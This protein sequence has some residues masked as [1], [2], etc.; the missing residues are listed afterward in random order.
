ME[1]VGGGRAVSSEQIVVNGKAGIL[2]FTGGDSL[3][4]IIG[5][6]L[7]LLGV[8]AVKAEILDKRVGDY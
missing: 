1:P 4:W 6:W 3:A 8:G 5:V 7:S 2:G